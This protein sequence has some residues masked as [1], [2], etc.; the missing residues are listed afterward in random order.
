MSEED[1]NHDRRRVLSAALQQITPFEVS[2]SHLDQFD[3][4]AK[5]STVFVA[6]E[7]PSSVVHLQAALESAFPECTELRERS[8]TFHP[9][10]TL[11]QFKGTVTKASIVI[12]LSLTYH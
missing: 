2:L 11:G 7:D 12:Q 5:S 8:G 1:L 6:P 9:H 4:S 10:L 3:H